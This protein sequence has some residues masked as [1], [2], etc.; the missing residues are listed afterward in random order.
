MERPPL[1]EDPDYPGRTGG[2]VAR[3]TGKL[4][5]AAALLGCRELFLAA[6]RSTTVHFVYSGPDPSCPAFREV[7]HEFYSGLYERVK[8]IYGL[9]PELRSAARDHVYE[10]KQYSFSAQLVSEPVRGVRIH[11]SKGGA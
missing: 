4:F 6:P 3:I 7:P 8:G 10:G 5:S 2:Y 1:L 9:G 11:I